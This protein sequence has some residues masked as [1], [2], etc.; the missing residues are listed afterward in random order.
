MGS[1]GQVFHIAEN[2][3]ILKHYLFHVGIEVVEVAP[4]TIKKFATGSGRAQKEDMYAAFEKKTEIN[5]KGML[6]PNRKLGSPVTDIVDAYFIA[7]F[8]R[9]QHENQENG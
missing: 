7:E 6:I 4:T 1:K 8:G 2:T 9:T 3:A 5:L